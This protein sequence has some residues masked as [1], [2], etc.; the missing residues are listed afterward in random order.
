MTFELKTRTD[1]E[2]VKKEIIEETITK[3]HATVKLWA[4]SQLEGRIAELEAEIQTL[5]ERKT[6]LESQ[7]KKFTAAVKEIEK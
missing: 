5:Q 2:G 6:L 7:I 3:T 4:P 1:P